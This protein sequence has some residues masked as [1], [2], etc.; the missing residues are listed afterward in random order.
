MTEIS[1]AAIARAQ[2]HLH[3]HGYV[4]LVACDSLERELRE[5][6]ELLQAA[7]TIEHATI[8]IYMTMLYT[9][10]PGVFFRVT[11]CVRSVLIEE[12]LHLSLVANVMNAVGGT[13]ALYTPEM[14]HTY[15]RYLP[16]KVTGARLS[17]IGFSVPAAEQ[18]KTIE[19]A[20]KLRP[21]A[22]LRGPHEG[23]TI[24]EFYTFIESK[25]RAMVMR[26]GEAEVFCGNPS[27]Q[28]QPHMFY[29][30]GGGDLIVVRGLQDALKALRLI[31]DQGEGA[32]RGIWTEESEGL[33]GAEMAHYFRFDELLKGRLYQKGDTIRSGPTGDLLPVPWEKANRTIRDPKESDYE[34]GTELHAAVVAFN[35]TYCKLLWL[36]EKAFNGHAEGLIE[37]VVHMS[38]L[39]DAFTR[40][41]RNPFPGRE[42]FFAAPSFEYVPYEDSAPARQAGFASNAQTLEALQRAYSKGNLSAA[43]ACMSPDVIWDISGP[44]EVPYT[45][46]YYGH[47]GFSA[48]WK[49]LGQ[50]VAFGQA[51]V[52]STFV[53]DDQA[54]TLGGEEGTV[55]ANNAPYHYDWAVA[56]RFGPD[57]KIT[58]MRQYYDPSRIRAA[59]GGPAYP[60]PAAPSPTSGGSVPNPQPPSG[61]RPMNIPNEIQQV[62]PLPDIPLGFTMPFYYAS[63][64]NV[65]VFYLVPATRVEPYLNGTGLKAALFEDQAVVSYNF[66]LYCGHFSAGKDAPV[67]QWMNSGAGITQELELNIVAFP[68]GQVGLV[69]QVSFE[70]FVLGDEQSKLLGNHRVHVPCDAD[71]AIAAG[72]T[73]FGEPKFKTSFSINL[74][75][76]NP[77]RQNTSPYQPEWLQDWGFQV[78]DPNDPKKAIFKCVAKLEGLSK[79]PGNISP[80]TEYGTFGGRLIGCRWNLLQP[81]DTYFLC[82][83]EAH[84]VALTLGSSDHVMRRDMEKLIGDSPA[85]AVQTFLSAPAAIQSRAYYP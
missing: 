6:R 74:P 24:G 26:F 64:T 46:M 81:M 25:L 7:L 35:R 27:R 43:L 5:L 58:S 68:E 45:G 37:A 40:V 11:D 59:I 15:P 13:V 82:P 52:S 57:H 49:K 50:T 28:V 47:T 62:Q 12:M 80:I 32:H 63:L 31:C 21:E 34:A 29:Y 18:G 16:Y 72:K 78:N 54:V 71:I 60:A 42:G 2:D 10:Q 8:P 4:E 51:G 36:L 61:D 70:Q 85:R 48:F 41:V 38:S 66:Q 73:L 67:S 53:R 30:D 55:R 33:G 20:A 1:L 77:V 84:R 79:V 23:M 17:L 9:T 56:Y 75:S 39:R 76:P 14:L 65:S 69:S 83:E 22:I 3:Q 44:P 19:H